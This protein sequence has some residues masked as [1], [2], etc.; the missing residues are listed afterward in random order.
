MH[1]CQN[2][3]EFCISFLCSILLCVRGG[4][5]LVNKVF[6]YV[7]SL[8]RNA[9]ITCSSIY[10]TKI[11]NE[12]HRAIFWF[13]TLVQAKHFSKH[14]SLNNIYRTTYSDSEQYHKH[15]HWATRIRKSRWFASISMVMY[16]DIIW[17]WWTKSAESSN[18]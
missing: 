8:E 13:K 11:V 3:L 4:G 9:F 15:Q 7:I 2:P 18:S 1:I 10:F 5:G 16:L 17:V 14:Q 12:N 6:Y